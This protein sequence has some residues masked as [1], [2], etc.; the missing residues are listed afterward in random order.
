MLE[1]ILK[2][3][4]K[5]ITVSK[6]TSFCGTFSLDPNR[7]LDI[8]LDVL[9]SCL[10]GATALPL[11][12]E[13]DIRLAT[14]TRVIRVLHT[15]KI[16]AILAFK[17]KSATRDKK[18]LLQCAVYLFA[19]DLLDLID[20]MTFFPEWFDPLQAMCREHR[21][22][23]RK[24]IRALGKVRLSAPSTPDEPEERLDLIP[25]EQHWTT[26]LIFGIMKHQHA[27]G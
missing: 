2:L 21:K 25:L 18:L 5:P 22:K 11:P 1:F 17:M 14:I 23:E 24:R 20:L 13:N 27:I 10:T 8:A 12:D 19:N 26:Q 4:A 7:C 3:A 9:E 16:T 6:N 15:D